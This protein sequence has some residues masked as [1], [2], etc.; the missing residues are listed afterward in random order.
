[1]GD[2]FHFK[3]WCK[4]LLL[5]SFLQTEDINA[6]IKIFRLSQTRPCMSFLLRAKLSAASM[7]STGRHP[8]PTLAL[9]EV[10][11]HYLCGRQ[12]VGVREEGSYMKVKE[13]Q[14]KRNEQIGKPITVV[15]CITKC[16]QHLLLNRLFKIVPFLVIRFPLPTSL[17]QG[18][19][20]FQRLS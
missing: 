15:H 7:G 3:A 16:N 13:D 10:K 8:K 2:I 20:Q 17:V 12:R 5:W 6:A 14:G 1:M 9:F 18:L 11:R 4:I 19:V